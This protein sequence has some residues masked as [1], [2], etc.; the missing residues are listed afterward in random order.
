MESRIQ[1]HVPGISKGL[2]AIRVQHDGQA[3]CTGITGVAQTEDLYVQDICYFVSVI[4]NTSVVSRIG[5][6]KDRLKEGFVIKIG[7]SIGRAGGKR[8]IV[9]NFGGIWACTGGE[10]QNEGEGEG[11]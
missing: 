5:L 7:F 8:C 9:S 6:R 2:A 10:R 4:C 3:A 1:F 11:D